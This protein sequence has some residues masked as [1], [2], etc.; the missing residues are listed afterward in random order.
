MFLPDYLMKGLDNAKTGI[1][2]QKTAAFYSAPP[3]PENNKYTPLLLFSAIVTGIIALT[4]IKSPGLKFVVTF[5]DSLLFFV[6]GL[7]GILLLFMWFGTNHVSCRNN[8]NLL[9][10]MPFNVIA[11]LL[12]FK[13]PL[14]FRK[15]FYA[16]MFINLATLLF[17]P[18]LPQ[19]LNIALIPLVLLLCLRSYWL[20]RK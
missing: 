20:A 3:A 9:W 5:M 14:W 7:L 8:Y 2:K 18:W 4:L 17:W 12:V 15:Y 13:N 11:A 6:T 10:A 1:V 19:Q 16:I